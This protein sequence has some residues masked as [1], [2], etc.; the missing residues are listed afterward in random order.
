MEMFAE[1]QLNA[2]NKR[3]QALYR[4]LFML[5]TLLLILPVVIILGIFLNLRLSLWVAFGIPFSFLGL[6]FTLPILGH[7]TWHLYQRAVPP[8]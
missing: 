2:K 4:S 1:S 8:E 3:T 6:I 5:M 7:T